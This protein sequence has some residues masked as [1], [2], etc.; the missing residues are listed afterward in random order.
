MWLTLFGF[1]NCFWKGKQVQKIEL[2]RL[3]SKFLVA[4]CAKMVLLVRVESIVWDEND[5]IKGA[6]VNVVVFSQN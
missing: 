3:A 1:L 4:T 2:K 6:I 5:V